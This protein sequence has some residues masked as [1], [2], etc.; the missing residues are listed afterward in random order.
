[1]S[2]GVHTVGDTV[3]KSCDVSVQKAS[4]AQEQ[5]EGSSSA[6]SDYQTVVTRVSSKSE[7]LLAGTA[8]LLGR[9]NHPKLKSLM[10]APLS[11]MSPSSI[12]DNQGEQSIH[13]QP[14][15]SLGAVS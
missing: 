9:G 1:V 8:A 15:A 13:S 12:S 11:A 6:N 3:S 10:S 7:E 5:R 14:T 2:C 4:P